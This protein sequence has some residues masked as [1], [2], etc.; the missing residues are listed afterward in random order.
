MEHEQKQRKIRIF[1]GEPAIVEGQVNELLDDYA[2]QSV[3]FASCG[4]RVIVTVFLVLQSEVRKMALMM[5]GN[6][7]VRQH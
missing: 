3:N 7:G 1:S 6:N 4:E 2:I 5:P